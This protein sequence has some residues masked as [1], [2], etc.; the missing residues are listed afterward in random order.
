LKKASFK[1]KVKKTLIKELNGKNI[2]F[3]FLLISDQTGIKVH[4]NP[5]LA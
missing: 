5:G 4:P 2:L 3:K 1:L